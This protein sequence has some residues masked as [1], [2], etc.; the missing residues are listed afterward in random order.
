MNGY[1]THREEAPRITPGRYQGNGMESVS[2]HLLYDTEKAR[3]LVDEVIAAVKDERADTK[4]VVSAE[5]A[6]TAKIQNQNDR[7][8]AVCERELRRHDLSD[9]RRA[10]LIDMIQQARES[11]AR[12]GE[13]SRE[14]Q[15]QQLEHSH[16]LPWKII[17]FALILTVGGIGGKT[18]L[19][20]AAA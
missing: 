5:I 19:S 10:E 12:E 17:L 18:L 7:L 6:S 15:S 20:T 14:F 13:R 4:K 8:I 2:Y 3:K 11:T 9:E 1:L 16:E